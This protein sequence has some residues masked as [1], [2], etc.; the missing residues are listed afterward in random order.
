MDMLDHLSDAGTVVWS[1]DKETRD[2][3]FWETHVS[4]TL[5]TTESRIIPL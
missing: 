4:N 1:S 2:Y 5:E 3:R